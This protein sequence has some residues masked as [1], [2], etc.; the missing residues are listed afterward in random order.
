L[1]SIPVIFLT[2]ETQTESI[3]KGFDYGAADYVG[4]PFN[5]AELIARVETHLKIQEQK[6]QIIGFNN[7][8]QS[9]NDQMES[10]LLQAAD[11]LSSQLPE[12]LDGK[13]KTNFNYFPAS[14]LGGDIFGYHWL[15]ENNFAL[16]LIDVSG[17]GV[18][19]ALMS[20]SVLNNIKKQTLKDVNYNDPANLLNSFNKIYKMDD[21]E[22]KYFT[23]WYGVI[24]VKDRKLI[25]SSAMH[26]PALL[27]AGQN[28]LVTKLGNEQIMIGALDD[29]LF[30]NVEYD[31]PED[32]K[33]YLFSDGSFEIIKESGKIISMDEFSEIISNAL[34]SKRKT[35]DEIY[36]KL[37]GLSAADKFDD[38]YTMIEIRV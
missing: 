16:Y 11:Y 3:I 23:I 27:F 33:I 28:K 15:D 10:E 22:N 12:K 34:V 8:L 37:S 13:V 20:V 1:K 31:L 19:A 2:S 18:G 6:N 24:N 29:T 26:P 35:I 30:S 14:H 36:N 7:H 32:V 17:H 9:I 5:E 4:K 38:D 21:H 25:C